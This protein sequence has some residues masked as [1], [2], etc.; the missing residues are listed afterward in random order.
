MWLSG[1]N[2]QAG[3]SEGPGS[4]SD[5]CLV[6]LRHREEAG[7]GNSQKMRADLMSGQVRS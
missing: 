2:I 5:A 1:D 3:Q 6:W 4:K 7:V